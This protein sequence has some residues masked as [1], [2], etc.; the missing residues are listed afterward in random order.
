MEVPMGEKFIAT[1]VESFFIMPPWRTCPRGGSTTGFA[2]PDESL[3][4]MWKHSSAYCGTSRN[5]EDIP[6]NDFEYNGRHFK[7][8]GKGINS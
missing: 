3:R 6:P 1:S 4:K 7:F 2:K 8:M 5:E